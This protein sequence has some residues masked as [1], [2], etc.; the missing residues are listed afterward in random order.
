MTNYTFE[1]A[2]VNYAQNLDIVV[3][4]PKQ[5]ALGKTPVNCYGI[6]GTDT[7]KLTCKTDTKKKKITITDA[8]RYQRGNPGTIRIVIDSLKNPSQ[9]IVTDSFLI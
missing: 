6:A 8:V 7:E 9:N 4:L 5:I 2:P 1:L 3:T